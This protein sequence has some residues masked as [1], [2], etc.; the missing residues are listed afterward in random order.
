[1]DEIIRLEETIATALVGGA[2]PDSMIPLAH[3]VL[4]NSWDGPGTRL[5][6]LRKIAGSIR[7]DHEEAYP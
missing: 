7:P 4:C 2:L 6:R 5:A 1:M 3:D